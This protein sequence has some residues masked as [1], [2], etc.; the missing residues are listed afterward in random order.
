MQVSHRPSCR[1]VSQ[2]IK[3][4]IIMLTIQVLGPLTFFLVRREPYWQVWF[5]PFSYLQ[6][7][8]LLW[9]VYG[10]YFLKR[11]KNVI[12]F[13]HFKS[14]YLC[15]GIWHHIFT[16]S[17]SNSY[18]FLSFWRRVPSPLMVIYCC[19]SCIKSLC[20]HKLFLNAFSVLA[21]GKAG[22]LYICNSLRFLFLQWP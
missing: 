9:Y 10:P 5:C 14:K 20:N 8:H 18:G 2:Q 17:P 22:M 16:A 21:P 1:N 13:S 7:E 3:A 19:V 15:M 6:A 12:I 11:G 4:F